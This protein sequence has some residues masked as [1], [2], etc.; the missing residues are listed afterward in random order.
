MFTRKRI[1]L[2]FDKVASVSVILTLWLFYSKKWIWSSTCFWYQDRP[3]K[4]DE[5][6]DI[7]S[8]NQIEVDNQDD[9]DTQTE[10]ERSKF[11]SEIGENEIWYN[12]MEL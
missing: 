5:L 3:A 1:L 4:D 9:T 7:I 10:K 8:W 2:L 6:E 11:E 12:L